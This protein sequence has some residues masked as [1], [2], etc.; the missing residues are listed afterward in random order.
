[1]DFRAAYDMPVAPAVVTAWKSDP[2]AEVFFRDK[3]G[4][5][6]KTALKPLLGDPVRSVRVAA[7]WALVE[8]L[9]RCSGVIRR[10]IHFGLLPPTIWLVTMS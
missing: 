10:T 3:L 7:A 8:T 9:E 4:E 5:A 2:A 6:V 1:M